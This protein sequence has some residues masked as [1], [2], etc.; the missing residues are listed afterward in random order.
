M[1]K[2]FQDTPQFQADMC[3]IYSNIITKDNQKVLTAIQKFLSDL[4]EIKQFMEPCKSLGTIN[5]DWEVVA[6]W[7]KYWKAQGMMKVYA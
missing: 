1:E 7:F 4:P 5:A 3:D 2:C 6:T